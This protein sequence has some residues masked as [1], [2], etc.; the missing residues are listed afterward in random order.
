MRNK[1]KLPK[2]HKP[3]RPDIGQVFATMLFECRDKINEDGANRWSYTVAT[4]RMIFE[5]WKRIFPDQVPPK[6]ALDMLKPFYKDLDFLCTSCITLVGRL[7]LNTIKG[8]NMSHMKPG[9]YWKC[10]ACG[11]VCQGEQL[12]QDPMSTVL[13]WTCSDYFCGGTCDNLDPKY[14]VAKLNSRPTKDA[15]D[16]GESSASDSESKP[17]PKRVI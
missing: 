8:V 5:A 7:S 12:V 16:L 15:P 4:R 14:I 11:N 17:A 2:N 1:P 6:E 9:G 3:V 13:K 10:R